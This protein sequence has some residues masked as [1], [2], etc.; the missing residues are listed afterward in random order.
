MDMGLN[1]KYT[2]LNIVILQN[3]LCY[4]IVVKLYYFIDLNTYYFK[5]IKGAEQFIIV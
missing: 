4:N 5:R 1:Y 2:L 3:A